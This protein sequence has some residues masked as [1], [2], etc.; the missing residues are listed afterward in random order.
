MVVDTFFLDYLFDTLLLK[1]YSTLAKSVFFGVNG[2][3]IFPLTL[4]HLEWPKF[5]R[6]LAV[7]S[8][9]GLKNSNDI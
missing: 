6:V 3:D 1:F 9:I 7:L 4:L 5:H 8:A 2:Y